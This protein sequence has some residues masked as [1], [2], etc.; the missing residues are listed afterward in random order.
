MQCLL[1]QTNRMRLS[2]GNSSTLLWTLVKQ[3]ARSSTSMTASHL[4][5]RP[6]TP[7]LQ[8]HRALNLIPYVVEQ[9]GRG[10]RSYDIYSRYYSDISFDNDQFWQLL[11]TLQYQV[12]EGADH[13][14]NGWDQRRCGKRG[15]G[16]AALPAVREQQE[17]HPHVHQ[18]PWWYSYGW[19][20]HL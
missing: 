17:T 20:S 2:G 18:Q 6:F 11:R 19:T 3:Q 7:W 4:H 5:K 15:G 8:F 10:E 1:S 13:M 16:T 9:T 14:F 12:A